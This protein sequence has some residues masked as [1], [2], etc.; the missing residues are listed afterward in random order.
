M[1]NKHTLEKLNTDITTLQGNSIAGFT[2]EST[3]TYRKAFISMCEMHQPLQQAKGES[4]KAYDLGIRFLKAK[5]SL[6]LDENDMEFLR[7]I[8][9]QSKVFV[10]IVT[11][12]VHDYL[13]KVMPIKVEEKEA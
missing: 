13:N 2:S 10:S 9:L 12:R 5:D 3:L 1:A 7:A 8:V 6:E 4:L 11:G